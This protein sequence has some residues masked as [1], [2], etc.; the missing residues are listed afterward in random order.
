MCGVIVTNIFVRNKRSMTRV[1]VTNYN[2]TRDSQPYKASAV[3]V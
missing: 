3:D 1:L 2:I